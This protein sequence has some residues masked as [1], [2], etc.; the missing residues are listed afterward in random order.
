MSYL[1]GSTKD[2]WYFI[3]FI[4]VMR[5]FSEK[6]M[7]NIESVT[8]AVTRKFSREILPQSPKLP[9]VRFFLYFFHEIKKF[10]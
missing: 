10:C 4:Y 2:Y 9:C 6:N 8:G 5:K 7:G 1:K 3:S